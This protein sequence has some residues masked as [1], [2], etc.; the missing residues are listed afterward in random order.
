MILFDWIIWYDLSLP[1]FFRLPIGWWVIIIGGGIPIG[2]LNSIFLGKLL[3]SSSQTAT[4]HSLSDDGVFYKYGFGE[5]EFV[6]KAEIETISFQRYN[7]VLHLRNGDE[8][9]LFFIASKQRRE[10]GSRLN[11]RIEQKG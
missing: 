3:Y 10:M 9:P 5:W 11:V 8:L 1:H 2:I 4:Q 7:L 6:R